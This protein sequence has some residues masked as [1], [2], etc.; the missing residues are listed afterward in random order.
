M[1]G[2]LGLTA[3]SLQCETGEGL[4]NAFYR[5]STVKI[6]LRSRTLEI[7]QFIVLP[8]ATFLILYHNYRECS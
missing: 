2:A 7:C 3:V 5:R 4:E 1:F 6:Y 8:L